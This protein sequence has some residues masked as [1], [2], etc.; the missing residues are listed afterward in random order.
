MMDQNKE[1]LLMT[2]EAACKYFM[3]ITMFQDHSSITPV[4]AGDNQTR[5]WPD[6][7]ITKTINPH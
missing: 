2:L 5:G 3:L 7:S 4:L 6:W 1:S